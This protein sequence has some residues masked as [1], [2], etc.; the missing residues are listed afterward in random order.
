[1]KKIVIIGSGLAGLS[2]AYHLLKN[3][4]EKFDVTILEKDDR[5][6]GRVHTLYVEGTYVDLGGFMILPFYKELRHLINELGLTTSMKRFVSDTEWYQLEQ[7]GPLIN[8]KNISVS[9]LIPLSI[10]RHI[11]LP[12]LEGKIDFYEP[13]FS[14]F[15]RETA[16]EFYKEHLPNAF[17][18]SE[19]LASEIFEAYTYAPI[20]HIPMTLCMSVMKKLVPHG[21]HGMLSKCEHIEGG[22]SL[23]VGALKKEVESM[24][25]SIQIKTEVQKVGSQRIHL[26]S[27]KKI[28]TDK[29]VFASLPSPSF[30]KNHFVH[31][32]KISNTHFYTVI[33]EMEHDT[34]IQDKPWFVMY[35]SIPQNRRSPHIASI[36]Q[37]SSFSNLSRKYLVLYLSIHKNDE[38]SY[39]SHMLKEICDSELKH[40]FL[41]NKVRKVFSS[42]NWKH[43]MP[44]VDIDLLE[45]FRLKQGQRGFYFAGDYTGLP[46]MDIATFSGRRVAEKI[47]SAN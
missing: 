37:C 39:N 27:G 42:R 34:N 18:K 10:F 5:V 11:I 31:G 21:M 35:C 14:L 7:N 25:G 40:Y 45:E 47:L 20:S 24:G 12:M 9:K 46:C 32:E 29:I 8:G 6:G 44:I 22:A 23:I 4:N 38:H 15:E 28:E 33:V 43:T 3:G 26:V 16:H 19:N 36:G 17:K 30:L 1:M 13:D 2:A 41:N